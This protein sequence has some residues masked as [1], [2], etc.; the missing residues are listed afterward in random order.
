MLFFFGGGW[1]RQESRA[2][3][4]FQILENFPD[5]YCHSFRKTVIIHLT[6]KWRKS[7]P[8]QFIQHREGR[9]SFHPSVNGVCP[10]LV[11]QTLVLKVLVEPWLPAAS[12]MVNRSCLISVF[13]AGE[14]FMSEAGLTLSEVCWSLRWGCSLANRF[15]LETLNWGAKPEGHVEPSELR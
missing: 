13:K 12:T 8:L 9:A 3:I 14:C 1:G 10:A 7:H 11:T 15:R 5:I 6:E 2:E 4:N